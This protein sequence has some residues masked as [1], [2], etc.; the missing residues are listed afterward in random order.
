MVQDF[1]AFNFRQGVKVW[2]GKDVGRIHF[3]IP[4]AFINSAAGLGLIPEGGNNSG[5][6]P[7]NIS[8]CPVGGAGGAA[9]DHN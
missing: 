9:A 7:G 2:I 1:E 3:L 5:G 6:P 8:S 4:F